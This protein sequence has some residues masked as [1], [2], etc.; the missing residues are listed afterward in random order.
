MRK[1][2]RRLGRSL[3]ATLR[4]GGTVKGSRQRLAHLAP[5]REVPCI[6]KSGALG[7]F[8]GVDVAVDAV[9]EQALTVGLVVDRQA[10]AVGAQ[11]GVFFDEL[12]H[13]QLQEG[14]DGLGF[15]L[16][17]DHVA[18]PLAA[19]AAALALEGWLI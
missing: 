10:L 7:G 17:D 12:R 8:D 14:G 15:G 11:A 6:G 16:G 19:I 18:G 9:E 3:K 13:W 5:A 2:D 1:R 4:V